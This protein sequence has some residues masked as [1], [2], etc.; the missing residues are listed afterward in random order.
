MTEDAPEGYDPSVSDV[1]LYV[2]GE[3]CDL[4]SGIEELEKMDGDFSVTIELV[5]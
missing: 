4:L 2:P 5:D 1:T 3:S